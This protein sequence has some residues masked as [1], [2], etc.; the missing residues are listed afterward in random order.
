MNLLTKILRFPATLALCALLLSPP[1]FAAAPAELRLGGSPAIEWSV[2][3]G[4]PRAALL[5]LHG[6]GLHKGTFD[7]F[8][9]RMAAA[10]I[11][12]YAV[13]LPGFGENKM[14]EGQRLDFDACM[15]VVGSALDDVRK[16]NPGIPLFL[17]GNQR[18][19]L[20]GSIRRPLQQRQRHR[21]NCAESHYR[22]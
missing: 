12:T 14:P 15:K 20:V 6:L 1:L 8:G 16:A 3:T 4:K 17:A 18:A 5:C 9:K 10:G 21:K 19:H 7:T 11:A 22:I 13:D 2:S